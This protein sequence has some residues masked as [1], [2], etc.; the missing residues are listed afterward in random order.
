MNKKKLLHIVIICF[1][2]LLILGFVNRPTTEEKIY[3]FVEKNKGE[4]EEIAIK[5]LNGDVRDKTYENVKVDGIFTNSNSE[6]IVQ[7]FYAGK[8]IVPSGKYYGF[9]YSPTDK[10]VDYQNNGLHL[11]EENGVW[12]WHQGNSDNGGITKKISECWY[13]YEAWF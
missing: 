7:F 6:S 2:G 1:I 13:Y 3:R 12:K 4:L 10:P 11:E 8:G 9:Y 5:H